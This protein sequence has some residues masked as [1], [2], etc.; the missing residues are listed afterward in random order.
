MRAATRKMPAI[1]R[2]CPLLQSTPLGVALHDHRLRLTA[3]LVC[4]RPLALLF[5]AALAA[6]GEEPRLE[7]PLIQD[8]GGVYRMPSKAE[9][10]VEGSRLVMDVTAGDYDGG[11]NKGL[12]RAA[13]YV[14][15]FALSG[16][17]DWKVSIVM[18]G[19]ATKEAIAD[20]AYQERFG[21]ANPNRALMQQLRKAGVDIVVCGQSMAHNGFDPRRM[22]PEVG[23]ALSAA[24]AL[25][26]RQKQGYAYLPIQ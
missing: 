20:D 24:T 12:A 16:I 6:S 11:V 25:L 10:P 8:H 22:T 23:L 9:A 7:Y 13:R 26:T 17:K 19:G 15:L 4:M 21:K 5:L 2:F 14:N 18:H 1:V 3:T